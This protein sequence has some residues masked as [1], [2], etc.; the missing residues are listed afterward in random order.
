MYGAKF[1]RKKSFVVFIIA[2]LL[3]VCLAAVL[4][5]CNNKLDD[6]DSDDDNPVLDENITC[7]QDG[8]IYIV[9]PKNND[10]SGDISLPLSYKGKPTKVG[11]FSK[12]SNLTSITFSGNEKEISNFLD[13]WYWYDDSIL[14]STMIYVGTT[15]IGFF[16]EMPQ[17]YSA[18]I[19]EGTTAIAYAAFASQQNLQRVVMPDSVIEIYEYAVADCVNLADIFL[20]QNIEYVGYGAFENTAWLSNQ[21]DG[22]V[23]IGKTL[24]KYKGD[25]PANTSII[26]KDGTKCIAS[27]AFKEYS[28]L[29]G[30][31]IP[32]SVTSIGEWAFN[33]CT[34]LMNITIPDS[35]ISIGDKVFSGTAWYDNQPDGLVYAGKVAYEYKGEMPENTSIIIKD[36]TK[37]I[38]GNAFYR[39]SE[40]TSITIPDSVTSIGDWA[41][42]DCSGLTNITVA[43]GNTFYHSAGNCLIETTSKTLIRGCKTSAI[44][45]DGSVTSIGGDAFSGCEGLTNVIIP[46]SVTEI[47]YCAFSGCNGLTS[48]RISDNVISIGSYAFAGCN[49]LTNVIIPDSVTSIGDN[50]FSGCEGLVTVTIPNS[51][52]GI[53]YRAFSDCSGLTS[54]TISDSVIS[55]GTYVFAGCS[56]LTSITVS[57]A[58]SR[59]HSEGN[60]IIETDTKTLKVG[61]KTSVIPADGSVTSIGNNAFYDCDGLTSLKIPD[62]V[63]SIGEQAFYD[64]D[65]L[66]SITIPDSVTSIGNQAFK[67]CS[68]LARVTI[69]N[70]VASIG[71]EAFDYCT[72]LTSIT[73]PE[74]VTSIDDGAFMYCRGLTSITIPSNLTSISYGMFM[75]CTELTSITIPND[76]TSI[77]G[78]AF[79][80]CSD[81]TNVYYKGTAAD[82]AKI[83]IESENNELTSATRYYYSETE[84]PMNS[85]GTDYNGNY[86]HYVDGQFVVWKK[87]NV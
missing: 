75:Y 4:V 17:N 12:C 8:D 79:F 64:C 25:M 61:C 14:P 20:S 47:G 10:I 27:Y 33:G 5:A 3:I 42:R 74:S 54:I 40:L 21:A 87:G 37:S 86:W 65:G 85:E 23:Y 7:E 44:P 69:G 84:P 83:S 34:G 45:T 70:R 57:N 28:S 68:N 48:I 22:I 52:T 55:I 82:W 80:G 24:Y 66:T 51:V 31:K 62:S 39:C 13:Y 78:Y 50:A 63:T 30:I 2:A 67:E 32:K 58:N 59:Y 11:D 73:I 36:G 71:G 19:K 26:I 35:V 60:C 1:M 29:V 77:G 49:R 53:G 56:G 9:A 15:C 6:S 18:T 41:F 46:D 43:N 76:V 72:L 81:L 16:G 38:G